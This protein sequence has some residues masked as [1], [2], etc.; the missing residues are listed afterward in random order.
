M[1]TILSASWASFVSPTLVPKPGKWFA[2]VDCVRRPRVWQRTG[3][4]KAWMD[5]EAGDLTGVWQ[6]SVPVLLT[7]Q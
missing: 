2:S 4:I 1:W 3:Y 6:L 5:H 7:I